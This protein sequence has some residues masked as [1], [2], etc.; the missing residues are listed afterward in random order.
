MLK[1]SPSRQDVVVHLNPEDFEQCRKIQDR[2]DNGILGGITLVADPSV[3][4][5]ECI[6]KSPKGTIASIIDQQ[7]ER[8]G[9]A[10]GKV[11]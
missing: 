7:L 4:R 5:A 2:K 6:L 1:N 9:E 3:G 11:K 8:I 10:L